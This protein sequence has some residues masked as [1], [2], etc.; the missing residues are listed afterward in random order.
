VETPL[1]EPETVDDQIEWIDNQQVVSSGD[2][3]LVEQQRQN[4]LQ[5]HAHEHRDYKAD[6]LR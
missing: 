6:Q 4:D 3:W 1:A 2:T 5:P